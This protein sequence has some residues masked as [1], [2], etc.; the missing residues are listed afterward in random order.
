MKLTLYTILLLS[1][2]QCAQFRG[3]ESDSQQGL[4]PE[5]VMIQTREEEQSIEEQIQLQ[6]QYYTAT[7]RDMYYEMQR[8]KKELTEEKRKVFLQNSQVAK[9]QTQD[10]EP[11]IQQI[12]Q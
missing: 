11:Q 2:V 12:T 5:W 6:A 1:A 9:Q 10:L 7:T 4:I 8:A 3:M